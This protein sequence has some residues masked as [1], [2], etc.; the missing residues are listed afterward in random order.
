MK[1]KLFSLCALAVLTGCNSTKPLKP[2]VASIRTPDAVQTVTQS[3]NP[4]TPST[5][6]ME[7][8]SEK[9]MVVPAQSIVQTTE[10][11]QAPV[12][13]TNP[14][15]ATTTTIKI[16]EPMPIVQKTTSKASTVLG[17]AQK[18]T[19]RT[20]AA[21]MAAVRPVQYAGILLILGGAALAYFGW[22]TKAVL[23]WGIGLAMI[24][25]AAVIPGHELLILGLGLAAFA[26][27]ALAILYVYHKGTLDGLLSTAKADVRKDHPRQHQNFMAGRTGSGTDS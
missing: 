10:T 9:T 15:V 27:A 24:V 4:S 11:A 1:K 21:R 8:T 20:L 7:T 13:S 14:P 2:G 23:A 16:A 12:G 25:V 19:A 22:W 3:E 6:Q 17:A 5:Q 18:D 26:V